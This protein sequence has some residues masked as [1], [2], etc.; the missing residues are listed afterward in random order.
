MKRI[1]MPLLLLFIL[2][3]FSQDYTKTENE[4]S[5]STND[6]AFRVYGYINGRRLDSVEASY[7]VFNWYGT[8]QVMFDCGQQATKNKDY[9]ITDYNGKPLTFHYPTWT[10]LLNFFHYNHWEYSVSAK[11]DSGYGNSISYWLLKKQQ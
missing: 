4:T 9:R 10:F 5:L 2:H 1:L 7:A 11:P 8:N 3:C 6:A